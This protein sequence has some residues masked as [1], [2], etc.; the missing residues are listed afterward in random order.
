MQAEWRWNQALRTR[1]WPSCQRQENRCRFVPHREASGPPEQSPDLTP[2]HKRPD[3]TLLTYR[4]ATTV[5]NRQPRGDAPAH[6]NVSPSP[7]GTGGHA[8]PR[9][10]P[11]P[12]AT[13]ERDLD[14]RGACS[15]GTVLAREFEATF[16]TGLASFLF[17]IVVAVHN[18]YYYR[19]RRLSRS[20]CRSLKRRIDR[21]KVIM[22]RA[23]DAWRPGSCSDPDRI[24]HWR[25]PGPSHR[26][27][28]SRRRGAPAHCRCMLTC[29]VQN[30]TRVLGSERALSPPPG[31]VRGRGVTGKRFKTPA[32]VA[33]RL[34]E[35][36]DAAGREFVRRL[37]SPCAMPTEDGPTS[38]HPAPTPGKRLRAV[39]RTED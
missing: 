14:A 17:S 4:P 23:C 6:R 11:R 35:E 1:G 24:R 9:L 8:G 27:A 10:S 39:P 13:S 7:R 16:P 38:S 34:K 37:L 21:I 29:P 19:G 3:P 33:V 30:C 28:L 5:K 2:T 15:C 22:A 26:R 36:S 31:G 18:T 32:T 25:W 20:R 12:P